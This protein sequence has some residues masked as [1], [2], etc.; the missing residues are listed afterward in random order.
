VSEAVWAAARLQ[1][2]NAAFFNAL[3]PRFAGLLPG[4]SDAQLVDVLWGLARLGLY[5]APNMD[6]AAAEVG[7]RAGSGQQ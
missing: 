6:A 7:C 2:Y 3:R 1:H 5:D 4:F